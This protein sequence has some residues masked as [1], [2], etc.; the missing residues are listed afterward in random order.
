[1]L[2][3]RTLEQK[4]SVWLLMCSVLE[5]GDATRR[6]PV[7]TRRHQAISPDATCDLPTIVSAVPRGCEY[8]SGYDVLTYVT[9]LIDSTVTAFGKPWTRPAPVPPC[10]PRFT[11]KHDPTPFCEH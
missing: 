8:T 11:P 1:M 9:T 4:H 2:S 6:Y 10:F 7:D 3:G 5:W